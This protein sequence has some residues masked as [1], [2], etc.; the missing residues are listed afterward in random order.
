MMTSLGA[1]SSTSVAGG[2]TGQSTLAIQTEEIEKLRSTEYQDYMIPMSF[3]DS[4]Q[5]LGNY[6][7]AKG[8]RVH[9]LIEQQRR[10]LPLLLVGGCDIIAD[11][12]SRIETYPLTVEVEH[13]IGKP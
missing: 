2:S 11:L 13:E 7:P 1:C 12:L 10:L 8:T 9:S 6:S 3:E 4:N 5:K